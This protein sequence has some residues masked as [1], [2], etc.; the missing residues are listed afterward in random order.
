MA[1]SNMLGNAPDSLVRLAIGAISKPSVLEQ[2]QRTNAKIDHVDS[3]YVRQI[4]NVQVAD[5]YYIHGM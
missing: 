2:V 1:W 4:L 3:V 5:L